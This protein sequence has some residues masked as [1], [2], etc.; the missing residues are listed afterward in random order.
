MC[1]KGEGGSE[2]KRDE[3]ERQ[4]INTERGDIKK[5]EMD[6]NRQRGERQKTDRERKQIQRKIE[7]SHRQRRQKIVKD[8][9]DRKQ[10]GRGKRENRQC[11]IKNRN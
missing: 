11:W 4:K 9:E 10:I 5:S 3:M 6:E 1:G 8:R 2:K 7:N